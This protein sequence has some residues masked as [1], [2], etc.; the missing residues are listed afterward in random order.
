MHKK[1]FFCFDYQDVIDIRV[2]IV[3]NQWLTD[4]TRE[5]KGFI[6]QEQWIRAEKL[7]DFAIKELLDSEIEQSTV[8][9]VLIGTESYSKKWVR[10]SI[11]KSLSLGHRVLGIHINRIEGK[12]LTV[13][14]P[15]M[16]PFD[17]MAIKYNETGDKVELIEKVH[18]NWI[19]YSELPAFTL[20]KI[21]SED[22]WGKA[23]K[24]SRF[25]PTYDWVE[26]DGLENLAKWI[27]K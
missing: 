15:G 25:L 17:F 1:V 16:N 10:Y 23:F 21:A 14:E 26:N 27:N 22:K 4:P 24:L 18:G 8:T 20:P 3:N 19:Q 2:N 5:S 9:L 6:P 11:F 7:G 12:D 13:K